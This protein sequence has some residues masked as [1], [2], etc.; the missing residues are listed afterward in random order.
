M[1]GTNLY[2]VPVYP[3]WKRA[4]VG[5]LKLTTFPCEERDGWIHVE[6]SGGTNQD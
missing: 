5:E 4:E 3:A 1:T 2:P 6:S